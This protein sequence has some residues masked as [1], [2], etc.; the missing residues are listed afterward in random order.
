LAYSTLRRAVPALSSS[1]QCAHPCGALAW[2]LAVHSSRSRF[3]ARLNSGV[4]RHG[5]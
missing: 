2:H 3:A 1:H 4:S 5:E